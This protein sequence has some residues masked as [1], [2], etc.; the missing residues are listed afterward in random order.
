MQL[1]PGMTYFIER[2]HAFQEPGSTFDSIHECLGTLKR[3]ALE[4]RFHLDNADAEWQLSPEMRLHVMSCF[5]DD[6]AADIVQR[7]E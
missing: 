5:N 7:M 1:L 3:I 4:A 2:T 6:T